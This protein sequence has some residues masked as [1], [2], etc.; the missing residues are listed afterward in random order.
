MDTDR[1]RGPVLNS[2]T[3]F[4]GLAVGSLGGGALV[5]YAPDPQHLVYA[6]LLA[7]EREAIADSYDL[8]SRYRSRL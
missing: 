4:I 1:S 6:V 3:A 8:K 2:I 5:T 7:M